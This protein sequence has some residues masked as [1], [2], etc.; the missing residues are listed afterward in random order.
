MCI[1]DSN[2]CSYYI[3]ECLHVLFYSRGNIKFY[4][5]HKSNEG[6][7]LLLRNGKKVDIDDISKYG[8]NGS[9][10]LYANY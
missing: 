10:V 3:G 4:L 1:R 5:L 9:I 2:N 6:E 8:I 7:K